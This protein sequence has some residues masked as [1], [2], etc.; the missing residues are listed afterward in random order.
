MDR[1]RITGGRRLAGA[2][3]ISGAKNAALPLMIASLLTDGKLTLENVPDLADVAL[4]TRIL[5]NHGVDFMVAGK[6]P[7]DA[8]N[9]GET[10][11]LSA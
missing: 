2:I 8:N 1:I 4:L 7:G 5:A 11:T 6:R 10:L 3:P 9:A